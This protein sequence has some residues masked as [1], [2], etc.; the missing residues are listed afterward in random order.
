MP[1]HLWAS[2]VTLELRVINDLARIS[3]CSCYASFE[4]HTECEQKCSLLIAPCKQSLG[5][6]DSVR[7]KTARKSMGKG[8]K[9]EKMEIE[10]SKT[11]REG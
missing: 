9:Q 7:R 4:I 1:S 2:T 11:W 8:N 6:I 10:E 5:E 3:T